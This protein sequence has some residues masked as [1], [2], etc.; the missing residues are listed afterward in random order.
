MRF[1]PRSIGIVGALTLLFS[2]PASAQQTL[3][4]EDLSGPYCTDSA[5]FPVAPLTYAGLVWSAD[6][7]ACTTAAIDALPSS[8]G[9]NSTGVDN[10]ISSGVV[11]IA[12]RMGQPVSVIQSSTPFR[13][14]SAHFG[15]A[16]R[17]GLE[18]TIIGRLLGA[19]VFTRLLTLDASLSGGNQ[20]AFGFNIDELR[21]SSAVGSG[22]VAT[23]GGVAY[24]AGCATAVNNCTEFVMD[25]FAYSDA[26]VN[27]EPSTVVLLATGLFGLGFYHRRRRRE[28]DLEG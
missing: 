1:L 21:F 3:D 9:L 15:S 5:V 22:D 25:D 13:F 19:D 2:G 7:G 4:F 26:I 28:G 8:W 17:D 23:A 10:G 16:W 6:W 12:N 20:V 24:R 27:P 11:G 18:V 14:L